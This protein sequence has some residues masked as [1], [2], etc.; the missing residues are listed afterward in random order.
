MSLA[1]LS[2][3]GP[4]RAVASWPIWRQAQ[5]SATLAAGYGL[6]GV[7]AVGAVLPGHLGAPVLALGLVITLRAS[8]RARRNFIGLQR[9][10]PKILFPVRRLLRRE[11]EVAPVLWQAALRWERMMLP[12]TWRFAGKTRRRWRR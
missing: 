12:R 11:P 1:S 3:S 2:S 8:Y 6:M 9:R 7:G 10:H 5:R 4:V